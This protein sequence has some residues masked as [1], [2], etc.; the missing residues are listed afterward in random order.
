MMPELTIAGDG[1]D[2]RGVIDLAKQ[3][4]CLRHIRFTGQLNREEL[5]A[6][7][8]R[9]DIA[10]QPSLTESFGK[11]WIDAMVH[12]LPVITCNVGSAR[13]C[14]GADGER[15]WV[16][17]PGDPGRLADAIQAA[18]SAELDWPALRRRCR[19]Y[20]ESFTIENWIA[21]IARMCTSRWNCSYQ[22]KLIGQA[23]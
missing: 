4:D 5:S 8:L 18:V 16:T 3:L 22:G 11:A 13:S 2:R 23:S 20:A 15:G 21:S 17:P 12:G 6:E 9:A 10:V 7:F 1:P 19:T 14:I